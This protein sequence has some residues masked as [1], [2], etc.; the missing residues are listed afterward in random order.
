MEKGK[1]AIKFIIVAL[2]IPI[3]I[4]YFQITINKE[5]ADV[6]FTL[7]DNIPIDVSDQLQ[8]QNIQQLEVKNLGDAK[9]D[10]I[11]VNI[12]GSNINYELIKHAEIDKVSSFERGDGIQVIYPVLPSHGSFKMIIK[13][14][15]GVST[16]DLE[17]KHDTGKGIEALSTDNTKSQWPLVVA[18]LIY[19]FVIMF[20]IRNTA[21]EYLQIE[22]KSNYKY[23]KI[24]RQQAPIYV[25]KSQW[26]EIRADALKSLIDS[27]PSYPRDIEL[28]HCISLLEQ[29]KLKYINEEEL[30]ELS[31]ALSSRI[32]NNISQE[33]MSIYSKNS[34]L[35]EIL[36]LKQPKHYN[37]RKWSELRG[38][39]LN[40]QQ[41]V[42][43][44][45]AI[46]HYDYKVETLDVYQLLSS[47]MPT[48]LTE[49]EWNSLLKK[50]VRY[51]NEFVKQRIQESYYYNRI[52]RIMYFLSLN[53]PAMYP[54]IE[55]G[56][57]YNWIQEQYI[58][59]KKNTDLVEGVYLNNSKI[60][61]KFNSRKPEVID[62]KNWKEYLKFLE[63]LY[64][65][66]ITYNIYNQ[67]EPLTFLTEQEKMSVDVEDQLHK[68]AYSVQLINYYIKF[69]NIDYENYKASGRPNWIRER[70][71]KILDDYHNDRQQYSTL[72][73]EQIEINAKLQE[74]QQV[75]LL[76]RYNAEEL[77]NK[78]TYQLNLINELL[79]DPTAIDRIEDYNKAFAKGNFQNL[80]KCADLMRK[81]KEQN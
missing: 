4:A 79:S 15:D 58:L 27:I 56:K 32:E 43:M 19:S 21:V 46:T 75:L 44:Y 31:G 62:D 6:K 71:Y 78:V 64:E 25:R 53:K 51:F 40:R 76:E 28:K 24:L 29:E 55:W 8:A 18:M 41:E 47:G 9:A 48:Y 33:I 63:Q 12:K 68:K 57:L 2:I 16:T 77:K 45:S 70:D 3:A 5:S 66:N 37:G 42:L 7:S 26:E 22:A 81:D 59:D 50:L 11:V 65:I 67:D 20:F 13:T 69:L 1:G 36:E 23:N 34:D 49:N 72:I 54:K 35:A 52:E 14:K 60:I 38:E 73:E 39:V 74:E 10:R 80:I 17:I 30:L 61:S